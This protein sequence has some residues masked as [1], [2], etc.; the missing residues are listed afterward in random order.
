MDLGGRP[1][2]IGR[3]RHH[4][5]RIPRLCEH[6]E[7]GIFRSPDGGSTWTRLRAAPESTYFSAL[8]AAGSVVLA[9]SQSGLHRSGDRGETWHRVTDWG[10]DTAVSAFAVGAKGI[11][12]VGGPTVGGRLHRS[13]DQGRTW[14][15]VAFDTSGYPAR[16]LAV[17]GD[18]VFVG[19]GWG[20]IFRS[21]DGGDSW[22]ALDSSTGDP[23]FRKSAPSLLVPAG[24]R[25]FG[26]SRKNL[27]VSSDLGGTWTPLET[28]TT[29]GLIEGLVAEDGHLFMMRSTAIFRSSDGGTTWTRL[30]VEAFGLR[31]YGT[32]AVPNGILLAAAGGVHRLQD[33]G[34]SLSRVSVGL[35]NTMAMSL[36]ASGGHLFAGTGRGLV[37][38][39]SDRGESWV[40]L[41]PRMGP[42]G[43]RSVPGIAFLDSTL[44]IATEADGVYRST[45]LGATLDSAN[46]GLREPG[47]AWIFAQDFA[48]QGPYVFVGT[49]LSGVYRSQDDGRTW[50]RG[51]NGLPS[52]PFAPSVSAL[53]THGP[54]LFAGT[55][56]AGIFRT[57]DFG[58]NW[59]AV[60]AGLPRTQG[61]YGAVLDFAAIGSHLFAAT[62]DGVYRTSDDGDAWTPVNAWS[63][64]F[65]IQAYK[66]V[67][68]LA[69][70][71]GRLFAA[72]DSGVFHSSDLG[73]TW[74]RSNL[75]LTDIR[76]VALAADDRYLYA[77]SDRNERN[78]GGVWR[79][80]LSE[81]PDS[82]PVS[83]RE[84]TVPPLGS[85]FSAG[86]GGMLRP[87]AAFEFTLQR[88]SRVHLGLF[89]PAGRLVVGVLEATLPSGRH[90]AR[91]PEQ[92]LPEGLYFLRLQGKG[93]SQ[94]V[95]IVLHR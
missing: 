72:N 88:V 77:A 85:G 48:L 44:F 54:V 13:T 78:Q 11:F 10:G 57:R 32:A 36:A 70:G 34:K 75:G 69:A 81:F 29:T 33:S 21:M 15:R 73:D 1:P 51:M 35:A 41:T 28:D 26:V 14:A 63:E 18:R 39:S 19:N 50:T 68:A 12:S 82:V 93:F 16:S 90:R 83:R 89:D 9:G 67:Y 56:E 17:D 66:G 79:R 76:I 8:A 64:G 42:D 92:G 61:K 94:A 59:T 84:A 87:G 30:D 4:G 62:G 5:G 86:A 27:F 25:L 22:E 23:V 2:G 37:N 7:R 60:H 20:A 6:G 47:R 91:L 40:T 46:T 55:M 43:F 24:G 45:D 53:H 38:R 49:G 3:D 52:A 74:K 31:V 58:D 71:G 80:P 65:S 95:R